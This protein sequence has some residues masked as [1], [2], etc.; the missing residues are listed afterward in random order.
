MHESIQH[1]DSQSS[2]TTTS[3]RV[4]ANP[5][6]ARSAANCQVPTSSKWSSA[7]AGGQTTL[8][9]A[10]STSTTTTTMTWYPPYPSVAAQGFSMMPVAAALHTCS[11]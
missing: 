1:L 8:I 10:T 3:I 9:P 4:L 5:I 6:V 11:F 7:T 2:A